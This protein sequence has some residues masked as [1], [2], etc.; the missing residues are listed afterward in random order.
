M[1]YR[2]KCINLL[3]SLIFLI[4]VITLTGIIYFGQLLYPLFIYNCTE[5]SVNN[6]E[7][8]I[9]NSIDDEF[10]LLSNIKPGLFNYFLWTDD[11]SI[12]FLALY[13]PWFLPTYNNY[14]Y[15]IQR[16]DAIRYFVL[17]HYGGIYLDTDIGC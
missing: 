16:A 3:L 8:K 13:Y 9:T 4:A 14:K 7:N 2:F 1:K 15:D 11:R 12:R 6:D 10:K 5:L 17:Y